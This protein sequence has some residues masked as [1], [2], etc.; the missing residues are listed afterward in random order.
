[1]GQSCITG[2]L[3]SYAFIPLNA[4]RRR[5]RFSFSTMASTTWPHFYNIWDGNV[6]FGYIATR[7]AKALR[8]LGSLLLRGHYTTKGL[9]LLLLSVFFHIRPFSERASTHGSALRLFVYSFCTAKRAFV[10]LSG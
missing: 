1:L 5:H 4:A 8:R 7:I 9:L 2:G 3:R 10:L 6:D